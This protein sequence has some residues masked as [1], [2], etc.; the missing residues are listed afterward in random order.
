MTAGCAAAAGPFEAWRD[1]KTDPRPKG[2]ER[3]AAP[4]G[5]RVV[6][7]RTVVGQGT[8]ALRHL[9]TVAA[10]LRPRSHRRDREYRGRIPRIGCS[11]HRSRPAQTAGL[12]VAGRDHRR[13]GALVWNTG[14]QKALSQ[15]W[16]GGV[17]A[18]H[19][20]ASGEGARRSR[21]QFGCRVGCAVIAPRFNARVADRHPASGRG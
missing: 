16:P 19:W 6:I 3:A 1:S 10:G 21:G 14:A 2:R 9:T 18:R 15:P 20:P 8:P 17:E 11:W 4:S 5:V 7:L 13:A 12:R